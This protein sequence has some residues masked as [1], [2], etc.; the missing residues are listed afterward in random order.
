MG[1]RIVKLKSA[2]VEALINVN[3]G[4]RLVFFGREGGEN[5]IKSDKFLL[6]E[7]VES[8]I[9]PDA[10]TDFVQFYGQEVWIGP[11]TQWWKHQTINMERRNSPINWPPDPYVSFGRF[12]VV[13]KS[14]TK[15]VIQGCV[16]EVSNISLRKIF[17]LN[18]K[19]L[20]DCAVE[21]TYHGDDETTID[22][23]NIVR[24]SGENVVRICG[25]LKEIDGPT[26]PF[27]KKAI[28]KKVGIVYTFCPDEMSVDSVPPEI[29]WGEDGQV[30]SG[31]FH[32]NMWAGI[33]ESYNERLGDVLVMCFPISENL[34]NETNVSI[35]PTEGHSLGEVYCYHT[36]DKEKSMY[37]LECHGKA[38][39]LKKGDTASTSIS[40]ILH[41]SSSFVV[42]ND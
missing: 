26:H 9:I 32:M 12:E 28:G 16:S 42:N 37:E 19:G 29:G 8:E 7:T 10:F 11:Q 21:A 41:H 4:G 36:L 30:H 3:V 38:V 35:Y 2:G 14:D 5:M 20:L 23:W 1:G 31:K 15:L 13:E 22:L 17:T 40:L 33:I 39:T 6:K 34:D 24:V 27:E 18:D 25:D